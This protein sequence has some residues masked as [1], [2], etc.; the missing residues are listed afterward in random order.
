MKIKLPVKVTST[1]GDSSTVRPAQAAAS[2][3]FPSLPY[4]NGWFAVG[5]SVDIPPGKVL[6]EQFMGQDIVVYRTRSGLLRATQPYCPHLGAHLGVR[7]SVDGENL[8][9]PFHG[10]TF[11]PSGACVRTGTGDPPPKIGLVLH[12]TREVN[13]IVL[14]WRHADGAAPDWEVDPPDTAGFPTPGH[15]TRILHDH[16]QDVMEN[17]FDFA[18]LPVVHGVVYEVTNRPDFSG[19]T[20][21]M[22]VLAQADK[23]GIGPFEKAPAEVRAALEARIGPF[24]QSPIHA[25]ISMSG[26][27]WVV[28]KGVYPRL[29]VGFI[30]WVLPTPIDPTHLTMRIMV[31][32]R[33]RTNGRE[34]GSARSALLDTIAS[35]L[36]AQVVHA[37]LVHDLN[38][39]FPIWQNKVYTERPRLVKGDGPIMQYRRWARQFYNAAEYDAVISTHGRYQWNGDSVHRVTGEHS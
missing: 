38:K 36:L 22:D 26:L 7:S 39:D 17:G 10:F 19:T 37:S 8:V 20:I 3:L 21:K 13:G 29:N 18:H 14:V 32:A 11:D 24:A 25:K 31:T 16:P 2:D 6:R 35:R 30:G 33:T 27:G 5:R 9:C 15:Y 34:A 28:V 4:P 1:R 23:L 12:P